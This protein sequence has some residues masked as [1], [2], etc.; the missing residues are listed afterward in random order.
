MKFRPG[1]WSKQGQAR[2]LLCRKRTVIYE[3]HTEKGARWLAGSPFIADGCDR[4]EGEGE[5]RVRNAEHE[6]RPLSYESAGGRAFV[7][8]PGGHGRGRKKGEEIETS[9]FFLTQVR[10]IG[11]RREQLRSVRPP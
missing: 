10:E 4:L 3:G 9:P 11:R 2:E 5:K 6:R 7:S 8:V 1:G